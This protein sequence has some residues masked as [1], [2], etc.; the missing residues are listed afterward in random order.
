VVLVVFAIVGPALAGH[1]PYA[2]DFGRGATAEGM[3][4]GPS[5]EFWLGTDRMFRD[6]LVRLAH[7][8]RL[9][10]V[11]AIAAT[12]ISSVLGAIVGVVSGWYEGARGLRVPWASV[13]CLLGAF[14]AV[15]DGAPKLA[16]GLAIAAPL[17]V[18]VAALRPDGPLAEGP[19]V[20]AD[21][22]LMRVVDVGLAFPFLLL[23]MALGA[24]LDRTSVGT[25]LLTLGLTSWLGTARV[26]RAKTLQ[27]RSADYVMAARALGQP[28]Y[29]VL[30]FHVL[31]NVIGP[32]IVIATA[33]VAQMIVA[34][35]VLSYL[36]VGIAPPTPT[37]GRM[38]YEGQDVYTAAPWLL[39]APAL[40]ILLS[41]L[42]FNLVGDGLRDAL[43]PKE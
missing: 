4:V 6:Q 41:V 36:G 7:G 15:V 42:G 8:A 29:R 12:A 32:L 3:P 24:A 40:A 28:I 38:L 43:D 21:H 10:L 18:I 1:D 16:L 11:V 33:Q 26:L 20:N 9:S 34:E 35:S 27:V 37:W 14:F 19:R 25:I 17:F 13:G 30:A 5:S 2:S 23:V 31:P 22:A 39:A